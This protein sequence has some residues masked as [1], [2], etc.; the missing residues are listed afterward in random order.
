MI[1]KQERRFMLIQQCEG[2]RVIELF[3]GSPSKVSPEDYAYLSS[4]SWHKSSTGYALNSKGKSMH[5]VVMNR[6]HGDYGNLLVDHISM[7][8]LDNRRSNLRLVTK[9]QNGFNRRASRGSQSPYKGIRRDGKAWQA[10]IM[11]DGK[12]FQIGNF[13]DEAE[14]AWMRDQWSLA[15]HQEYAQLNFDYQ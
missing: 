8:R 9:S 1:F 7:D 10:R 11:C 13:S 5:A 2:Y 4:Y 14:A 12:S 6:L 3:D 15:L